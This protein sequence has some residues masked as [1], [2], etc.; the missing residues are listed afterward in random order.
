MNKLSLAFFAIA[1]VSLGA[2]SG[3]PEPG[4]GEFAPNPLTGGTSGPE[5]PP[6]QRISDLLQEAKQQYDDL[7]YETSLRMAEQAEAHIKTHGFPVEDEV[8][9]LTIQGFSLLQLGYLDDYFV[10]THGVQS[11]AISKFEKALTR[12]D[13]S[14]RAQLGIGLALFRRHG[15]SI[16]KSER[17]GEGVIF[18][19]AMREDARRGF[20]DPKSE[21]GKLRLK[22][23]D[24]KLTTFKANRNRLIEL[25]Y[26]FRDPSTVP[27][28][29]DG[30]AAWLGTLPRDEAELAV[31]D[32]E[33]ILDDAI[34]GVTITGDDERLLNERI[35]AIAK[36]WRKVRKYWRQRGLNDLQRSRDQLLDLREKRVKANDGVL[37]YFWIDRDLTFVF[38]SLGAFFLDSG[39]AR[40]RMIAIANGDTGETMEG[41]ARRI[42]LSDNFNDWQKEASKANY[43]SALSYTESFIKRHRR[44]ERD[45][46]YAMDEASQ[47][48]DA[49]SN[50]FLV[51]LVRRYKNTMEELIQEERSVR[52]Q[53]VLEAAALCID[54]LFQVNDID[55]ANIWA[56]E[57]KSMDIDDPLHHFVRATAYYQGKEWERAKAEYEAFVN[58]SSLVM[59]NRRNVARTRIMQCDQHLS[60]KAGAGEDDTR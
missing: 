36:S 19:E 15:T 51:D 7:H 43:R 44:F 12:K 30:Q 49:N 54:P 27:V 9:A 59:T 29:E 38:Q 8:L 39:L 32:I 21:E 17:L 34:N 33:G 16:I 1:F 4:S 42:Y 23:A 46:V 20:D 3:T 53:M 57:L 24:R 2:C 5:T 26:V 31:L 13:D 55:K 14:F 37:D 45:R 28:Y 10:E 6:D 11:G 41:K 18:L 60:R 25:G 48:N 50:P 56:D 47:T 35:T 52:R 22:A 58:L 40:A